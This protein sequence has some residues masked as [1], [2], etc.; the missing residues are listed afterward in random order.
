MQAGHGRRACPIRRSTDEALSIDQKLE[1]NMHSFEHATAHTVEEALSLLGSSGTVRLIA[2]GTDILNTLS[3]G[4]DRPRRL[5]DLK[6][7]AE[8][9]TLGEGPEHGLRLGV[10]ITLS[11]LARAPEV[12]RHYNILREA[13]LSAG[14]PPTP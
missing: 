2:G 7:V 6:P 12:T 1:T 14:P 3:I 8:L 5:V 10:L 9:E 11:R 4:L 13:A